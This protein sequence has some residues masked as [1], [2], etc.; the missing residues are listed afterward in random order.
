MRNDE[1]EWRKWKFVEKVLDMTAG[2][3]ASVVSLLHR[4][5]SDGRNDEA[6]VTE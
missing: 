1:W 3:S 4:E 5:S 2:I 6:P